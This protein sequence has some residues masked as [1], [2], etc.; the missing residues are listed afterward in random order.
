MS[1]H[2]ELHTIPLE[3]TTKKR[4]R[5][6]SGSSSGE[7]SRG[8]RKSARVTSCEKRNYKEIEESESGLT[9]DTNND[10][11]ES[12]S[13]IAIDSD[14]TGSSN[15]EIRLSNSGVERYGLTDSDDIES[16]IKSSSDDEDNESQSTLDKSY[17]NTSLRKSSRRSLQKRDYTEIDETESSEEL[18][19]ED[20]TDESL[21][22]IE[23]NIIGIKPQIGM[24]VDLRDNDNIW[25]PA[26]VISVSTTSSGEYETNLR[27]D[28]WGPTWDE[29]LT[30]P[31]PRIAQLFTYTK[32]VKC[33]VD[34]ISKKKVKRSKRQ[35]RKSQQMSSLWPCR[36]SFRM[37]HPGSKLAEDFLRLE[38]NVYVQPYGKKLPS[39]I[40]ATLDNN[41]RWVNASRLRQWRF[42]DSKIKFLDGFKAAWKRGVEDEGTPGILPSKTFDC[43]SLLNERLRVKTLKGEVFYRGGFGTSNDKK[44]S[45]PPI[46]IN[47][48]L[49]GNVERSENAAGKVSKVI[50]V[51]ESSSE[52]DA[53]DQV[54]LPPPVQIS[55]TLFSDDRVRKTPKTNQFTTSVSMAGNELFL[56]MYP[57]QSNTL[58]ARN[59][60]LQNNELIIDLPTENPEPEQ[61]V[62]M[63]AA[64]STVEMRWDPQNSFSLHTW[65]MEKLR[66]HNAS[67]NLE[68]EIIQCQ[69]KKAR[70][71]LVQI[72]RRG[73]P[74]Y[75]KTKKKTS[76][77]KR[78]DLEHQC[79]L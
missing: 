30:W 48:K 31:N 8:R 22:E 34:W 17:N 57:S 1:S 4:K 3:G 15:R 65:T 74:G 53:E 35:D 41:Y 6:A 20:S 62:S 49:D 7:I 61:A 5:K 66:R 67:L 47:D 26:T 54:V 32:Q 42:H 52:N 24:R 55:D 70:R 29:T 9:D 23:S 78:L 43:G 18:P 50:N 44:Q 40:I 76:Q 77:P 73:W 21:V 79:Y 58:A 19:I 27:Y 36:V 33:L 28:G 16:S 11:D 59:K 38:V 46:V 14:T 64:I 25:S 56:G 75:A 2:E 45:M 71:G 39:E 68:K 72:A 10:N 63:E 13:I 51:L 69:A 60:I 37:P 12:V